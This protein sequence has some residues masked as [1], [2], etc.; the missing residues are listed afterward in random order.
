MPGRCGTRSLRTGGGRWSGWGS[1]FG[2]G[3]RSVVV[4]SCGL[5]TA[6]LGQHGVG[7]V[8]VLDHLLALGA[9]PGDGFLAAHRPVRILGRSFCNRDAVRKLRAFEITVEVV[10]AVALFVG[11]LDVGHCTVATLEFG[12]EIGP[13]ASMQLARRAIGVDVD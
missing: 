13:L 2:P 6:R 10:P 1:L 11:V 5:L 4:R 7:A 3:W 9:Q 8:G 12:F